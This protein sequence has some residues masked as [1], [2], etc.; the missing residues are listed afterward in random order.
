MSAVITPLLVKV[1]SCQVKTGLWHDGT[2]YEFQVLLRNLKYKID[3]YLRLMCA[4]DIQKLLV[5]KPGQ[6]EAATLA[7]FPRSTILR[8]HLLYF[9]WMYWVFVG[10]LIIIFIIFQSALTS[11]YLGSLNSAKDKKKERCQYLS[12]FFISHIVITIF[13]KIIR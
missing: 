2:R 3:L 10:T 5:N 6:S 8:P 1:I 11:F 13:R 9:H 4:T 12:M 7:W